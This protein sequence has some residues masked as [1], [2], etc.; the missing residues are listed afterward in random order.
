M[1]ESM[2]ADLLPE[3]SGETWVVSM[4][5]EEFTADLLPAGADLD[6]IV[7][8]HQDTT[9]AMVCEWVQ[10]GTVPVWAECAGLS[11][12]LRCWRLQV[13]NLSMDTDGRLWRCRAPPPE[14]SVFRLQSRVYWPGL[15]QDIHTYVASCTVCLARKSPCPQRAP[16]GHVAVGRRWER[17]AMD[18]LDLSI[19]SAKGHHYMLVMVDCFSRW[20]EAYPLPDKTAV[21]VADAFFSNIVCRYYP[22][23]KKCKLDSVWTGPYL[24]VSL[25]GWAVGIQ[26]H[27]DMPVILIHCQ[28]VKKV[29]QWELRRSP[30]WVLVLWH[31]PPEV[32]PQL[33]HCPTKRGLF[34]RMWIPYEMDDP[35]RMTE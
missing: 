4:P 19:T 28:D 11:P 20:T 5:L 30:C 16:M 21:S 2:D 9:L 10:S 7:V 24:V 8:S 23:G 26:K 12:E 22:A 31:T 17:V 35:L 13:G 15:R 27:P 3:L 1:G 32:H 6:L 25:I 34:S 29:P 33:L 18:L 14:G